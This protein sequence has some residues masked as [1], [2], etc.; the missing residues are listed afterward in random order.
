MRRP[1][2]RRP[3]RPSGDRRRPP[4]RAAAW[5]ARRYQ[6]H[7]RRRGLPTTCHSKVLEDHVANADAVCARSC[8]VRAPSSSASSRCTSS[9]SAGRA[10]TCRCRPRAI[11]GTPPPSRGLVVGLGV[12]RRRGAVP[13]GAR[14]RYRRQRAQS[15]A[16]CGIVG[17]K[18]TY[19]LVSRRGV[20]P[21]AF[22][23]DHVGPMT[24]TVA[25]NALLLDTI[26][27]H[28]PVDPGSVASAHGRVRGRSRPRGA[29]PAHRLRPPFPRD[30]PAGRSRGH[31]RPQRGCPRLQVEG[32][33]VRTVRLPS[34][35]SWRVNGSS[36]SRVLGHPRRLAARAAGRLRPPLT[37][38][39]M[40]GAF[41]NAGDYV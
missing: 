18:P 31:G 21:L 36:C 10:S 3:R 15:R 12:A 19:G 9:P 32:A 38:P 37:P 1:P 13:A 17:L 7:H 22:T 24:R 6:G 35:T 33:H 29:R 20:F 2:W 40:G 11:R 30:R 25:D 41:I 26:A 27:G 8:A 23:L 5:R 4:A 28:D 14:H 16:R 39:L 34:L